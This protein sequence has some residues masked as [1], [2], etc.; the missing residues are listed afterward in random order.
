[1][2][3]TPKIVSSLCTLVSMKQSRHDIRAA[4]TDHQSDPTLERRFIQRVQI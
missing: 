2:S 3:V 4:N 1:M